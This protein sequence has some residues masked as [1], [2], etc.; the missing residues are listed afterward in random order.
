MDKN[1]ITVHHAGRVAPLTTCLCLLIN[2][3]VSIDVQRA[4]RRMGH[5]PASVVSVISHVIAAKIKDCLRMFPDVY[6]VL[7][8]FRSLKKK[9]GRPA[10][11]L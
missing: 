1:R 10:F 7:Q 3:P 5:S 4:G 9:K 6:H 2:L 11:A 8:L